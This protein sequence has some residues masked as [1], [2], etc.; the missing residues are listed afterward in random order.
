MAAYALTLQIDAADLPTLQQAGERIVLA[1]RLADAGNPVV[2]SSLAP[3]LTHQVAWVD[4][5]F[6]FASQTPNVQGNRVLVQATAA[7]VLRSR[8][9]YS[10]N[11]FS[12]PV[13]TASLPADVVETHN[14]V[15]TDIASSMMLGFAQS[16]AVDGGPAGDPLPLNAQTV[17]ALQWSRLAA[18]QDVW[19]FLASGLAAGTIIATPA[20][21]AVQGRQ[22]FSTALL[23]SL[24]PSQP[25]VTARYSA[26]LGA[27]YVA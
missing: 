26:T 14:G 19:V 9:G 5:F 3:A 17:P 27:F 6:L 20:T 16:C 24:S 12:A 7:A 23:I 13:P 21:S 22:V 18:A 11:G 4:D 25:A 8:Y 2:W 1:R 10:I 15:G